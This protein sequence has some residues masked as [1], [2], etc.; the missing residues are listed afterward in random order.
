MECYSVS[1][2]NETLTR[3]TTWMN[4]EDIK[5]REKG[6]HKRANAIWSHLHKVP[7][8]AKPRA[9]ERHG[10]CLRLG[11]AR[12]CCECGQSFSLRREKVLDVDR[13]AGH[14]TT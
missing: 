3:V 9:R 14:K 1:K 12:G 6:R 2:R 10:G 7:R 11:V 13:G 8:T 4:P 5:F